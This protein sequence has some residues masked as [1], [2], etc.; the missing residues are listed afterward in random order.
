MVKKKK[1]NNKKQPGRF[2]IQIPPLP[3]AVNFRTGHFHLSLSF[4]I[5]K[6]QV[7]QTD[8]FTRSLLSTHNI[9][10]T[11]CWKHL[12]EQGPLPAIALTFHEENKTMKQILNSW[13][14]QPGDHKCHKESRIR[15]VGSTG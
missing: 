6:V 4:L 11:K 13:T 14:E 10:G 9:Q 3:L 1:K 7:K 5:H 12:G 8:V 2:F 15:V